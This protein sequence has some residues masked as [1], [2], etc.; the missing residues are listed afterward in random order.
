[1]KAIQTGNTFEIYDDSLSVF[2]TLPPNTYTVCFHKMKGFY[3]EKRYEISAGSEKIYGVHN[4]KSEKVLESF[5]L[6]KRNLGV[7]LSGD[8][9]IGKSLFTR[10]LAQKAVERGMPVLIVNEY[11]PGIASYLDS[12]RQEIMVLFDE[13]D[14][15][16]GGIQQE[17]GSVDPQTEL[18]GLFDGIASG[19]KLFVITCNNL[20]KISEYL[21]NRP[22]RFHYHF[23]FE[24]PTSEE[25][26]EY[27]TDNIPEKMYGEIEEVIRFSRMFDLNYDCLRSISFELSCGRSFSESIK[28]LNII[29]VSGV[30]YEVVLYFNNGY[31]MM[32]RSVCIN[33]AEKYVRVNLCAEGTGFNLLDIYFD[34]KSIIYNMEDLS[35]KVMPEN[36]TVA[37]KFEP[38]EDEE[39]DKEDADFKTGFGSGMHHLELIREHG[40]ADPH[41]EV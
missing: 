4:E 15:T 35:Q 10:L 7:I 18:L 21:V 29:N 31:K 28:D 11:I 34:P 27:L 8:K 3:L 41:Y 40:G 13:Y 37:Y 20:K 32:K 24:Y 39:Y 5:R 26:R 22:G 1:M 25:I 30:K 33:F 2:D 16:F 36:I 38:D 17:N 6:F 19:K 9:G 12:I 14:K 23:R